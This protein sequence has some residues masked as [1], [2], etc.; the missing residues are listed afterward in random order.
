MDR[1]Q[2][3]VEYVLR[4]GQGL[5]GLSLVDLGFERR[6]E[7]LT[8]GDRFLLEDDERERMASVSAEE[9][10]KSLYQAQLL[11]GALWEASAVLIDQLFEDIAQLRGLEKI[12]RQDIAGCFVLS[13][14]P[15][16]HAEKYDVRFAQQFLVIAADLSGA[17]LRGWTHPS[18]VAQELAV[19]CLLDQ[20]DV[21]QDLYSLDLA[22]NW[23]GRLEDRLLEDTDTDM[24]YQNAL[25]GFEGDEELAMQV[26][27][28]PM[29]FRDWFEPF[30]DSYV[31]AF[32][33]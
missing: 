4:V 14:L 6:L 22:E 15:P 2:N 23:R 20:V 9:R 5:T 32:A 24:L 27:L 31:P 33:R 25:D 8:E 28:A 26:G 16:R 30:N 19:R 29:H 18:C 10:D 13:G 7:D 3:Y 1:D 11:A 21:I 12:S 17:L